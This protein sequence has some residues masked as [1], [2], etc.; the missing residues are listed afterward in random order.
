MFA[1][2]FMTAITRSLVSVL[3]DLA[4][5]LLYESSIIGDWKSPGGKS[6]FVLYI[7]YTGQRQFVSVV[8]AALLRLTTSTTEDKVY[9][10]NTKICSG[11]STA[12]QYKNT[13]FY[14]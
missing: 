12:T 14:I 4:K 13:I 2:A 1:H 9:K 3:D 10:K 8:F 11:T 5:I 6:S 7:R